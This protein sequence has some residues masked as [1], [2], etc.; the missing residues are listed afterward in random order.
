MS[1][2]NILCLTSS[3]R[4]DTA[5]SNLVAARVLKELAVVNPD[6][7]LVVRDLARNPL[8]HVDEDFVVATRSLAGP[9]TERQRALLEL[10]DALVDELLAADTIVIAAEM[11]NFTVPSTLKAWID[12]VVRPGRTFRYTEAGSEGLL[13]GR[14]AIF[15]LARGDIYSKG[16]MMVFEHQESY[17]RAVLNFVGIT[18]IQT[19]L[20]E[21]IALGPEAAE[22]AVE[23]AM[24]R[25]AAVA[26]VLA[27]S[28]EAEGRRDAPLP[29]YA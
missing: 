19:I 27:N 25:A 3:P 20:L 7:V 6:A 11:V 15:V 24:Q 23:R 9:R 4:R 2:R 10:S 22:L 16:R 29:R 26:G 12:Y 1:T 13:R 17:L 8:P 18:D 14:R 5:Y 28:A 21:G